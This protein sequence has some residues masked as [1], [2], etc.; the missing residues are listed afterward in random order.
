MLYICGSNLESDYGCASEDIGE[1]LS[2]PNKPDDVNII[3]ETGGT[4]RWHRYNIA[5]NVLSRYHVENQKLVLDTTLPKENMGKQSTFESFLTWGL[6]SY[7]ADKT[8][9][10]LWNHGG[11][12]GGCCY[13]DSIGSSDSL[14]N[15]ETSSAFKK[16]FSANGV[17]KLEPSSH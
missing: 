11:A 6:Q 7:P 2:V 12:L 13:D 15:S 3:I 10:I 5:S 17:D 8:G 9:I 4:T 1:V 14:L 16:V